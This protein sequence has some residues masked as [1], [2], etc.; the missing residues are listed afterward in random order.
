MRRLLLLFT[1]AVLLPACGVF[2]DDDN[3]APPPVADGT[4]LL[5]IIHASANAPDVNL[6]LN[7]NPIQAGQGVPFKAGLAARVTPDSNSIA[8]EAIIPGGNATVIGPVDVTTEDDTRVTVFAANDVSAIEP[9]VLTAPEVDLAAGQARVRVLH[10]APAAPMVDVYVTAPDADLSAEAPL[11][12]VMFGD[13]F[14]PAEVPAGDYR[15]RITIAGDPGQVAFDSGTVTVDDGSDLIFAAVNNTLPGDA[16]V[17]L[18]VADGTGVV[19][20]IDQNTPA[21]VRV[22]HASPDAPNVDVL[23]DD[24]TPPAIADLPFGDATDRIP[25]PAAEYNFKVVPTGETE[26]VVI[27]ED[28]GLVAGVEY[29]VFAAGLLADLGSTADDALPLGA[30]VLTDDDRSVGTE[31]KLRVV[32]T[33]PAAGNVDVYLVEQGADIADIDPTLADVPFLADSGYLSVPPGAY[34]VIVTVTGSKMPAIGPAPVT[35]DA[36]GVY[37]AAARDADGGG[38]PLS[39]ILLDDFAAP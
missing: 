34:D 10:A 29:S 37:T 14:G 9:I 27:D 38:A 22:V 2:D 4:A 5:E 17:S 23:V 32:H 16:A 7:G 11:G 36:G 26:P 25:L 33:S 12:T 19:E 21:T 35:L 18:L 1:A 31:A 8:V 13:D 24:A 28:L 20:L 39:L 30:L 3:N 6:S 15:I